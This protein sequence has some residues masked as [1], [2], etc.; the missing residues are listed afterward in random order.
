MSADDDVD[1]EELWTRMCGI[2]SRRTD[3]PIDRVKAIAE[4]AGLS[5]HSHSGIVDL[6]ETVVS[7]LGRKS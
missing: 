2:I 4:N 3:V 7:E 5:A 1:E 6:L